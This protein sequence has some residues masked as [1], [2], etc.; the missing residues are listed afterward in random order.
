[1]GFGAGQRLKFVVFPLKALIFN[2]N[3]DSGAAEAEAQ[4]G[5]KDIL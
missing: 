4:A 3:F 5:F 1:L 2:E